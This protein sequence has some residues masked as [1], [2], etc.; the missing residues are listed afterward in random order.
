[1]G[2]DNF[3]MFG[4][5]EIV[6]PGIFIAL[7]LRFDQSLKRETNIYFRATTAAF[8]FGLLLY[9]LET[10]LGQQ[11]PALLYLLPLCLATPVFL[12]LVKGDMTAMFKY[13]HLN[14][15]LIINKNHFCLAMKTIQPYTWTVVLGLKFATDEN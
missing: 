4:L 2:T 13:V 1:M 12:A 14:T 9:F 6:I 10:N 8:A 11:Q 5:G 15:N 7:L 3:I